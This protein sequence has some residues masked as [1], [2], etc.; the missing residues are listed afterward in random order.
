MIKFEYYGKLFLIFFVINVVV[1]CKQTKIVESRIEQ[2]E[3]FT[4]NKHD[5]LK[6]LK[7]RSLLKTTEDD[8]FGIAKS[9]SS[10]YCVIVYDY[11]HDEKWFDGIEIWNTTSLELQRVI[12]LNKQGWSL[13]LPVDVEDGKYIQ[14]N[15]NDNYNGINGSKLFLFDFEN[16]MYY[17]RY[18]TT[19]EWS[20][21]SLN[22]FKEYKSF[23][24]L[25]SSYNFEENEI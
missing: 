15:Y 8:F 18:F 20:N 19:K 11:Y 25:K 21:I 6:L 16:M 17:E 2:L 4:W 23:T 13:D 1:S 3:N 22:W 10:N 5:S 12:E 9:S 7:K 14:V 24:K